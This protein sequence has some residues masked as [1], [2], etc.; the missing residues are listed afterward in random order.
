MDDAKEVRAIID[1]IQ[2]D[3]RR[4]D[5]GELLALLET[6]TG[7]K[8]RVWSP[9]TIGFGQYHYRYHTGQEGDFFTVG[10]A[11]R[12]DR[13]TLY[14]MSGLRGFENILARLGPH[15]ASKSTVHLKRLDDV[16]LDVLT[17]L[18]SECF[19]HVAEVERDLGA[20]PRMSDIPPRV[21]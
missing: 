17:E 6:V 16:D 8:P 11:P 13:L 2:L 5:A 19:R 7:E 12:K 9:G 4:Q 15:S 14:I 21:V 10:F 20:I 1:G 18:V 3:G